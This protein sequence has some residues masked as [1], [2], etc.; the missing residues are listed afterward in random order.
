MSYPTAVYKADDLNL[1]NIKFSE[2]RIN[3]KMGTKMIGVLYNDPATNMLTKPLI[4]TPALASLFGIRTDSY[5]D[6][7]AKTTLTMSLKGMDE[8]EKIMG[9]HNLFSGL[10]DL[11]IKYAHDNTQSL[12][13]KK[14]SDEV[15]RDK[16]TPLVKYSKDKETGEIITKYAPTIK[17]KVPRNTSTGDITTLVFDYKKN[18]IEDIEE[19]LSVKGLNLQLL[20]EPTVM[21]VSGG[22]FGM[23]WTVKQIRMG[24]QTRITGYAF[25]PDSDDEEEEEDNQEENFQNEDE[26]IQNSDAEV[27]SDDDDIAEICNDTSELVVEE[28]EDDAPKKRGRKKKN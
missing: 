8:N 15:I 2:P 27:N 18:V 5:E 22:K 26:N 19:A 12:F 14:C 13:K 20:V 10:D 21:W 24:K 7:P 6:G 11:M 3:P 4:Q 25:K 16:H 28:N 17:F 1:D 9:F 23:S